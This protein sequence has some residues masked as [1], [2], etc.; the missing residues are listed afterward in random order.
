MFLK[1]GLFTCIILQMHSTVK[2]TTLIF[3]ITG[4][5]GSYLKELLLNKDYI[6]HGTYRKNSKNNVVHHNKLF[7]YKCDLTKEKEIFSLIEKI[8]PDEIYNLGA[9]SSVAFSFKQ[10]NYTMICNVLGPLYIL[11]AIKK[12]NLI[13]K[14]RLY[15]ASSSEMFGNS[16]LPFQN[17]NTRFAPGSPYATSKLCA[18]WLIKNYREAYGIFACNGILFNHESERRGEDFVTRK[19]TKT[20]A[21]IAHGSEETLYLGNLDIK[22][23]WGY[24]PDYIEG[25]WLMLQQDHP[26]DYVIATGETHSI[27]EFVEEAFSCAGIEITWQGNGD[28][29]QGIDPKSK[30]ILVKTNP[31]F[32]RPNEKKTSCGCNKKALS[33]L[34]WTP[35]TTFKELVQKMIY[36]DLEI[37]NKSK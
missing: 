12:L 26:D 31:E 14:T 33:L 27:R 21:R 28:N 35:R 24:A 1:I 3:G 10:P 36:H 4:Q 2:K 13:K 9:Q 29:E 17:E 20:V 15:Q 18:H 37:T 19:I 6:V 23:D 11:D 25:M 7:L 5:D 8:K 34:K 32:F 22:R 16:N 30:K